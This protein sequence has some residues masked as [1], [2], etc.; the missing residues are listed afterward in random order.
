MARNFIG[1]SLPW[2]AY[3][4]F[5]ESCGDF[6]EFRRFDD[7]N[8]PIH[9]CPSPPSYTSRAIETPFIASAF[10]EPCILCGREVLLLVSPRGRKAYFNEVSWP[11][12]AHLHIEGRI[13]SPLTANLSIK[14]WPADSYRVRRVEDVKGGLRIWL[15]G[16][17]LTECIEPTF[18]K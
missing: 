15:Q 14:N 8:I 13:V 11:L 17:T 3:L 2:E 4:A 5:C 18:P 9:R 6:I 10:V 7:R 12:V 16:A 1:H